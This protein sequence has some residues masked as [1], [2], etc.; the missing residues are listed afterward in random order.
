MRCV[1]ASD[2]SSGASAA[3]NR[4]GNLKIAG[5]MKQGISLRSARPRLLASVRAYCLDALVALALFLLLSCVYSSCG[6]CCSL[7]A[8]HFGRF[9]GVRGRQEAP[10]G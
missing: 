6:T 9:W 8:L 2:G 5:S 10:G 4:W 1:M 7:A 3:S